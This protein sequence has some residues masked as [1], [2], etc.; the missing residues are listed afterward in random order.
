MNPRL[1]PAKEYFLRLNVLQRIEE[2]KKK[3]RKILLGFL[4]VSAFA[5]SVLLHLPAL[6]CS[7]SPQRGELIVRSPC[8][9]DL[10]LYRVWGTGPWKTAHRAFGYTLRCAL[11]LASGA[12]AAYLCATWRMGPRVYREQANTTVP[13][14]CCFCCSFF[15]RVISL[16]VSG[17][18]RSHLKRF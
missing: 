13:A 17:I 12:P 15:D 14:C 6:G 9:S 5:A 7:C 8:N 11:A 16:I 1:I 2:R 4:A 10:T 3:F 18:Y